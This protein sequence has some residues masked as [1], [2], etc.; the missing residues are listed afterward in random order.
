[1][2]WWL[3]VFLMQDSP[4]Q[5]ERARATMT[6]SIERQ[7]ASVKKQAESAGAAMYWNPAPPAAPACDPVPRP[8]L[9]KMIDESAKKNG[10]DPSLV[11]EVARQESG[12]R[13]CAVSSK[14]AQG[15][16]QLMPETQAQ[17]QVSDPFDP[18]Q[19]L[20]GGAKLLKQ[21]LDRYHGDYS[22]ALGAYNA[23]ASRV[24]K[25]GVIPGITETRNYV[26]SILDRFL[27]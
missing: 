12:F 9:S 4:A 10:V 1:M 5:A 11:R 22:L 20:D 18:R 26:L 14:G 23:G 8:E 2:T 3:A 13:P 19:S 7:R 24:D 27:R 16:M 17:M 15:L 6:A 25:A 21:L